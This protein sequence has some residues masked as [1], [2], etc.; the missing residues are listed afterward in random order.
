MNGTTVYLDTSSI[1]KRYV[2]ERG[3]H[4]VDGIYAKAEAGEHVITLSLWN[5]G[6]VLGVFDRYR[7][8]KIMNEHA[9]SKTL[10]NFLAESMKLIRLGNMHIHPFSTEVMAETYVI[11]LKHHI[12]QADALQIATCKSAK[13]TLLASADAHLL[14]VAK[15]EKINILNIETDQ[16]PAEHP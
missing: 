1:V 3:S 6:E 15:Q 8:R 4:L 13:S 7:S 9:F 11:I 5:I 2:E 12:Y 16:E 14:E 10:R